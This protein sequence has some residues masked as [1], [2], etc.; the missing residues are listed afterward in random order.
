GNG[1]DQA[2]GGDGPP[3][4]APAELARTIIG[5]A[6][7]ENLTFD[8][9]GDLVNRGGGNTDATWLFLPD[10][11]AGLLDGDGRE[12]QSA[13]IILSEQGGGRRRQLTMRALTAQASLTPLQ[14]Q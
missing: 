6:L 12:H 10:G 9:A 7:P 1:Q 5:K 8:K 3:A 4:D 11:R 13:S 2:S 14:Q